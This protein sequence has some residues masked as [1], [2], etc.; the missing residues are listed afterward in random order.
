L[1]ERFANS[2]SLDDVFGALDNIYH[3]A[4]EDPELRGWFSDMN[5]FIRY[6]KEHKRGDVC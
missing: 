4:D 1:I 5:T 6:A 2:T 3:D